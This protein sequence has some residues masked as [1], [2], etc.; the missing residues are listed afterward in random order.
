VLRAAGPA[1][2]DRERVRQRARREHR[3]LH[4]HLNEHIV[5]RDRDL[6]RRLRHVRDGEVECFVGDRPQT[7]RC[8]AP[9][10]DVLR[11]I[12]ADEQEPRI[13]AARSGIAGVADAVAVAIE[14]RRREWEVWAWIAR[15]AFGI[16]IVVALVWI[17]DRRAVVVL[18]GH[19]IAI[20]VPG[21]RAIGRGVG[22]TGTAVASR[23]AFID[24]IELKQ[25]VAAGET[26]H[27]DDVRQPPHGVQ[28]KPR[29]RRDATQFC[30][31][32][33]SAS[34]KNPRTACRETAAAASPARDADS[35]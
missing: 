11:V 27:P 7:C 19:Q 20:A 6:D 35:H 9:T 34:T 28:C 12:E 15:V 23:R 26:E 8:L 10:H 30:V 2:A 4:A 22:A 25:H 32:G 3:A 5:E 16:A 14:I 29:Q 17:V 1:D 21:E 18:V 31:I 33:V 13:R 24:V